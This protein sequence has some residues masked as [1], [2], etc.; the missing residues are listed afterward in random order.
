MLKLNHKKL[1][2]WK[3]SIEL[4]TDIY[5]ITNSFPISEL[6]GLVNQ[7]R[8]AAISVPSNISEGAA[9]KSAAERR[10]FFEISRSSLSEIDTNVVG[11]YYCEFEM[12]GTKGKNTFPARRHDPRQVVVL[13][14][15][16]GN[17]A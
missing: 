14:E 8:R 3:A 4:V 11:R 7:V 10:R 17:N 13:I 9:R 16:D 1:E 2:V 15:D 5:R 6:Y 12:I